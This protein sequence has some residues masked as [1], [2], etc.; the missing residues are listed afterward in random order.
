MS[1]LASCG[2]TIR[3]R[4]S[5]PSR[6]NAQRSRLS[7]RRSL[8]SQDCPSTT[9]RTSA[10]CRWPRFLKVIPTFRGARALRPQA[11]LHL[12]RH[13]NLGRKRFASATIGAPCNERHPI[14]IRR[15]RRNRPYPHL[16]NRDIGS[17][18]LRQRMAKWGAWER[19]S[20]LA[21]QTH[22]LRRGTL[23][24]LSTGCSR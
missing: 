16:I 4:R 15:N 6:S 23:M 14:S 17:V 7:C 13:A 8:M 24:M 2:P 3:T 10:G 18:T 12:L 20:F 21:K 11:W 5:R 19:C 9:S 22:W 1:P